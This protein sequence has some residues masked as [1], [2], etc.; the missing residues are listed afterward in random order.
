M[1]TNRQRM[2][3]PRLPT[4]ILVRHLVAGEEHSHPGVVGVALREAVEAAQKTV[5][6]EH[7]QHMPHIAS[8]LGAV[9]FAVVVRPTASLRVRTERPLVD[10]R[11]GLWHVLLGLRLARCGRGQWSV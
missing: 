9:P 2:H 4:G 5:G 11:S 6:A 8:A 1:R 7:T 10:L 3:P